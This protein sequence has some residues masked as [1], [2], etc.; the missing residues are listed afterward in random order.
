MDCRDRFAAWLVELVLEPVRALRENGG[1]STT[2]RTA[3]GQRRFDVTVARDGGDYLWSLREVGGPLQESA[4]TPLAD[5]E[6]AFWDAWTAI[7][8]AA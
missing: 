2:V 5:P 1:G 3:L 4:A 8:A 7:E 6:D